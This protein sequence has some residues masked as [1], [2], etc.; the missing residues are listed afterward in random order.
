M[1]LQSNII[2]IIADDLTGAND[3]ALQFHL[4]GCNTQI[5][6]DYSVSPVGKANTQAWAIS[7]ETRNKPVEECVDVVKKAAKALIENLNIEYLYKKIDSTLRGHIA[8]ETLAVLEVMEGD[9]AVIVPAFPAEGRTTVGGYHLLK[10]MPIERTD[11]ARD[12]HYPISQSHI[13]TLLQQQV[14]NPEIVA[15]IPLIIVVKGAGPI[16]IEL[17]KLIA[18]G[19]KL[20]VAD[21][22][23]TTDME[24]IALA[25]EKCT[26]KI[27]PCGAAGLAQVMTKCWLPDTKYQHIT[28]VIPFLPVLI[29]SGS[30]T[31]LSKVQLKK[32]A[33]F[34][35]FDSYITEL[36][37][38]Q[39]LN[40]PED[41]FIE[42]IK[43][44]LETEKIAAVHFTEYEDEN[45]KAEEV[46]IFPESIPNLLMEYLASLCAKIV[47]KQNL[48]FLV[49]GGETSYKCCNA[50]GSKHLQL[51]DQVEPAIPIC[52]DHEARWIVTKSGNFGTPNT[53]VNIIKYLKQH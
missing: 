10:G 18:E 16:L 28:K 52:L 17:K 21:A 47:K 22:V 20:I 12:P 37:L 51:I 46:G 8:Q 40:K 48:I 38:E 41:S 50:L 44:H 7:T 29:V 35:E 31:S 36:S 33:E 11:V 53:L 2:G 6:L 45:A 5:L 4:K 13:P 23:T 25:I 27:L 32:L 1:T 34:D 19:K 9:A 43:E 49:I 14:D 15:H 26:G 24:Q 39:I 3:T 42:N 30:K